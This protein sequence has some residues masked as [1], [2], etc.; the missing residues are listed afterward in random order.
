[1]AALR[2]ASISKP[3]QQGTTTHHHH[4]PAIASGSKQTKP[5]S[6]PPNRRLPNE[7]FRL[8]A[9][10]EINSLREFSANFKIPHKMP[11]GLVAD[12]GQR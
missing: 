5:E 4:D 12:F 8:N 3:A 7:S 2:N 9:Q 6:I 10:S 1:M 11:Q